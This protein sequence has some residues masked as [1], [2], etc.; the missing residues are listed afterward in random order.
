MCPLRQLR[1][2]RHYNL[3]IRYL[4][5]PKKRQIGKSFIGKRLCATVDL[6]NGFNDQVTTEMA[7]NSLK[8]PALMCPPSKQAASRFHRAVVDADVVNQTREETRCRRTPIG[9]AQG[10]SS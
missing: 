5:I 1:L 10:F 6:S 7:D 4:P 2:Q 8:Q 9:Q 3:A